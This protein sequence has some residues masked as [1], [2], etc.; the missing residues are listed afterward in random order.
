MIISHV[1]LYGA[2]SMQKGNDKEW[3]PMMYTSRAL[4]YVQVRKGLYIAATWACGKFA[5]YI[6]GIQVILETDHKPLVA[7][8]GFRSYWKQTMSH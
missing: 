7:L 4:C 6:T 1:A 2:V 8:L 5:D 3:H